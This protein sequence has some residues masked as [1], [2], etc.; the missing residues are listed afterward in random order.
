MKILHIENTAG[1]PFQISK[2]LCELGHESKVM[3]TWHSYTGHGCDIENYY[4]SPKK[5]TEYPHTIRSIRK[6][7]SIAKDYD[8][9]HVHG[10]MNWKRLE[11]P[12]LN[13]YKKPIVAHYHGSESRIGFG[14]AYQGIAK[15]KIVC[16]PDLLKWHPEA[17]LL[18]NPI[19]KK[20]YVFTGEKIRIV[21]M[22]T[23]RKKKGTELVLRAIEALKEEE[24]L[25]FEF[26]LVEGKTHKEAM[27][28]LEAAHILIDQVVTKE[29]TEIAGLIGICSLEAMSMGK[30]AVSY[31]DQKMLPYYN[32]IPVVNVEPNLRA[33]TDH[34][35]TL[36][37]HP[38]LCREIGFRSQKF[39]REEHST[40]GAAKKCEE[41]YTGILQN[42]NNGRYRIGVPDGR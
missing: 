30:V 20:P 31:I 32:G 15:A 5:I 25:S 18:L 38:E 42:L 24:E 33:L 11:F 28:E 8:I 22:P 7:I 12:I 6:T 21:H 16:T 40:L 2:A 13:Y 10:G 4:G 37:R 19:A 9:I 3:E 35:R 29:D 41:I 26:R 1:V 39:V 14:M 34:L 27:K 23:D 17:T 36:I